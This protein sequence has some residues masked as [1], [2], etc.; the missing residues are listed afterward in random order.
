MPG[1]PKGTG[2]QAAELTPVQIRRVDKCLTGTRHML[3]DR[4]LLFL[5]LGTGMRVSEL[6]N[7]RV[8]MVVANQKVTRQVVL[9]KHSTKSRR[10]RTVFLASQAV[11]HIQA[12]LDTRVPFPAASEPLFPSQ[13]HPHEPMSTANASRLLK[14]MFDEAGLK[15]VS[16]HSLRRT[17]ANSLRRQG[18]DLKIIQEQLGHTS[19]ATTERY[20]S[21]DPLERQQAV[22][23]LRF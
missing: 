9:E 17:H 15:N 22:D 5:G 10:S 7:L 14:R 21:A 18:V 13:M 19:L 3:R 2:G 20:F 6:A 23:L 16:S 8:G 4:A 1:R 12:Y 11:K